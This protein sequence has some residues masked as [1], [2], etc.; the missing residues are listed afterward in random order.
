M[1]ACMTELVHHNIFQKL[2]RQ[3]AK[4]IIET[5]VPYPRTTSPPCLLLAYGNSSVR[6]SVSMSE[7]PRAL[8][9]ERTR[10]FHHFLIGPCAAAH[11]WELN[12]RLGHSLL[13][14]ERIMLRCVQ[15]IS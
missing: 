1:F 5:Q 11:A 8:G 14:R 6:K 10:M 2:G 4:S 15:T 12:M 7:V 9:N 13:Y 3:E